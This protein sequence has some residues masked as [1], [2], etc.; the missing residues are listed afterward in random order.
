MTT[1]DDEITGP[2]EGGVG[3]APAQVRV[4]PATLE[5]TNAAAAEETREIVQGRHYRLRRFI[6]T[7]ASFLGLW[8]LMIAF[9]RTGTPP[10]VYFVMLLPFY[11][12]TLIFA[13][14]KPKSRRLEQKSLKDRL[15]FTN[16]LTLALLAFVAI[17]IPFTF[18]SNRVIPYAPVV[19][20]LLFIGVLYLLFRLVGRSVGVAPSLEALPPA[21]HR[22]HKQVVLPIDDPHYQRTLFQNYE[23]VDRGRGARGLAKR[24]DDAMEA[25]GIPDDRR[26]HIVEDL[27]DYH[28]GFSLGLGLTKRSRERN[29]GR[30]ERRTQILKTVYNKFNLEMENRA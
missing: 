22:R 27:H 13:L 20:F 11:A 4:E 9:I 3:E 2:G 16:K 21:N 1:G 19:E 6:I 23:F 30:R 17:Y 14:R 18:I 24:L 10:S 8:L 29:R 28:E 5:G 7:S 25:V 26:A 15:T 12:V